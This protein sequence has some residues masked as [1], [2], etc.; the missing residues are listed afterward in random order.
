[1]SKPFQLLW[2]NFVCFQG[3]YCSRASQTSVQRFPPKYFHRFHQ[4]YLLCLDIPVL[5]TSYQPSTDTPYLQDYQT[6]DCFV[7]KIL[8]SNFEKASVSLRISYAT[9]LL[10]LIDATSQRLN[11]WYHVFLVYTLKRCV[12]VDCYVSINCLRR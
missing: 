3:R 4:E 9:L 7:T 11:N 10:A 6:K 12:C 1:M 2:D 5:N 8:D